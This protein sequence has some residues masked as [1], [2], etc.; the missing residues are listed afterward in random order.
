MARRGVQ[1]L[2]DSLD[3]KVELEGPVEFTHEL[4]LRES[5]R[6]TAQTTEE[7]MPS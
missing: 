1:M 3:R 2:V 6:R 7:M 4:M 5:T